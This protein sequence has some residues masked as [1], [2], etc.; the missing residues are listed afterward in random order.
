MVMVVR[1]A[2]QS[3]WRDGPDEHWCPLPEAGVE[4]IGESRVRFHKIENPDEKRISYIDFPG[5]GP[6]MNNGEPGRTAP[7]GM[8]R[9]GS[10][11]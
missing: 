8:T 7:G 3:Y 6:I 2:G 10:E 5:Q 9:K 4:F 1:G 11:V